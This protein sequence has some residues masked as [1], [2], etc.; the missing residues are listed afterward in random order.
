MAAPCPVDRRNAVDVRSF[1]LLVI[2]N[3]AG[4]YN[5]SFYMSLLRGNGYRNV[6]A[7]NGNCHG[8]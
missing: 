5:L 1:T 7:E 4:S 3:T 6:Y 2:H 8:D